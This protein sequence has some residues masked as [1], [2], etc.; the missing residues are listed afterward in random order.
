MR[1][2]ARVLEAAAAAGAF[3]GT[4]DEPANSCPFNA[5][6]QP[7]AAL[8][9][10]RGWQSKKSPVVDFGNAAPV[11]ASMPHLFTC[12]E[13]NSKTGKVLHP[14][15]CKGWKD[16][17]PEAVLPAAPAKP[18]KARAPRTPRKTTPKKAAT[19]TPEKAVRKEETSP[20][21]A[22]A[23]QRVQ[24]K[25]DAAARLG[26]LGKPVDTQILVAGASND[27]IEIL[28]YADG[29]K[30]LRKYPGRGVHAEDQN[31]RE[32]LGSLAAAAFGLDSPAVF[33]EPDE[34][35]LMDYIPGK[36]GLETRNLD[37]V[38]NSPKGRLVAL[39]DSVIENE[40]RNRGN[41]IVGKDYNPILLDHGYAWSG[42]IH[43]RP[44]RDPNSIFMKEIMDLNGKYGYEQTYRDLPY[45][46]ADLDKA[47]DVMESLRPDFERLGR[48]EWLDNSL[49]RI[50]RM[51]RYAVGKEDVFV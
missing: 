5:V 29:S 25:K 47:R 36:T 34:T 35:I 7:D 24:D 16:A 48:R 37:R 27:G 38:V 22:A 33:R 51:R 10:V 23:V 46:S 12:R 8:A 40:D 9:W 17:M 4:R 42:S 18:A 14:G 32:E 28:T 30:A 50:E 1:M 19:P 26:A 20:A 13:G 6:A 2:D 3:A 15:P 11:V 31:D 45:T 49:T 44:M 41:F 21:A 39:F 43:G